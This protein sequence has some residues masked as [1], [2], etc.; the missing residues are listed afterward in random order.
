MYKKILKVFTKIKNENKFKS[1]ALHEPLID[2]TDKKKIYL[3]LKS[4]FVSTA[5]PQTKLFEKKLKKFTKSKYVICV[6]SGTSA[7]H[8]ALL[9]SKINQN[10]EVLVPSLTFVGTINPILYIGATPHFVDSEINNLG[11][12]FDKLENYLKKICYKK[13]KYFYNKKTKKKISSIIA[14]HIFGHPVNI[15]KLKK[16][17]KKFNLKIIEDAAEGLGSFYKDKHVGTFGD[18]GILSFNGNKIITTGSGG[19]ILTN[20]LHIYN[21]AKHLSSTAKKIHPWKYEHDKI[22]FN[23]RMPA[24]NASLGLSQIDKINKI[25]R[26]K[27]KLFLFYKKRFKDCLD[28]DILREPTDTKSNY[29]L[30]AIILKNSKYKVKNLINY[31]SNKNVQFRPVWKLMH[32]LK[33]LKNYPKMNLSNS[34]NHEKKLITIPSGNLFKIKV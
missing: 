10:D 31:A 2:E 20:N 19:A 28:V 30:Q 18:V 12:D 23:Y 25:L 27:R 14:V 6:N 21:A 11:I 9:A 22:G 1:L 29:W 24:L 33:H 17:S 16:I 8:I 4:N 32:K 13:G 15:S 3:C 26:F 34:S 5:G 7:I